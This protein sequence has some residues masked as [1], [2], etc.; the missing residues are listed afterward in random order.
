MPLGMYLRLSTILGSALLF[1]VVASGALAQADSQGRV[2]TPPGLPVV[3]ALPAADHVVT[4]SSWRRFGPTGG[5]R[6][7]VWRDGSH[8]REIV[9]LQGAR[10][11]GPG[12]TTTSYWNPATGGFAREFVNLNGT[13]QVHFSRRSG[14]HYRL[15]RTEDTRI[16]AGERCRIWRT[17]AFDDGWSQDPNRLSC[18]TEDGLLLHEALLDGAGGV[19][20]ERTAVTIERRNVSPQKVL[21]PRE[22]LDWAAWQLQVKD[23][24]P[25]DTGRPENYEL[26]LTREKSPYGEPRTVLY[27]ASGGWFSTE[28]RLKGELDSIHLRHASGALGINSYSSSLILFRKEPN[29]LPRSGKALDRRSSKVL[30]EECHWFDATPDE[31]HSFRYECRAEDGLPLIVHE[32]RDDEGNPKLVAV[33]VSR[34]RTPLR[35]V[36]LPPG[37]LSWARW[38]WPELEPAAKSQRGRAR[39]N[40]RPAP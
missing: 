3:Y 26:R 40:P 39:P 29:L 6:I 10:R 21:P 37:T 11:T 15:H 17:E 8:V 30:G 28:S 33:T 25:G 18:V 35:R 22:T 13:S 2:T 16:I 7:T 31:T 27:R 36:M 14:W 32:G 34:G 19:S 9:E 4:Y 1:G 24:E 5:S 20:E 12:V 38:G 23:L